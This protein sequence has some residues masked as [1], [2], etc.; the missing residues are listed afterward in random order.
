[1]IKTSDKQIREYSSNIMDYLINLDTFTKL[2]GS[3]A[4][5][6]DSSKSPDPVKGTLDPAH[7]LS[8]PD[9]A[10]KIF[11]DKHSIGRQMNRWSQNPWN[12]HWNDPR[13]DDHRRRGIS[14]AV[15]MYYKHGDKTALGTYDDRKKANMDLFAET[16]A[17]YYDLKKWVDASENYKIEHRWGK[18]RG[19]YEFPNKGKSIFTQGEKQHFE[20]WMTNLGLERDIDDVDRWMTPDGE[21]VD[22]AFLSEQQNLSEREYWNQVRDLNPDWNVGKM[23]E[24]LEWSRKRYGVQMMPDPQSIYWS[25]FTIPGSEE[26]QQQLQEEA[27]AAILAQMPNEYGENVLH[28][29]D[30]DIDIEEWL[31]DQG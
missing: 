28:V 15:S 20:D 5:F 10:P 29:G 25:Q 18:G 13:E 24:Q 7:R 9:R 21:T 30:S 17:P 2:K 22:S 8:S 27:L 6:E 11:Q 31:A 3:P 12:K 19:A 26:H 1:M 16:A 14:D 4:R 23:R